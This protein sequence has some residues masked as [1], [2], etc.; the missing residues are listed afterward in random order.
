MKEFI[1]K[2]LVKVL[3][4]F[5]KINYIRRLILFVFRLYSQEITRSWE[6]TLVSFKDIEDNYGHAIRGLEKAL[7]RHETTL[8]HLQEQLQQLVADDKRLKKQVQ[9]V[10]SEACLENT[11]T[12][13]ESRLTS[14]AALKV[15]LI[16]NTYNRLHT[17]PNTLNS[18]N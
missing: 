9:I 5:V 7:H 12:L 15:S 17:L 13:G 6:E 3:T 14:H 8:S 11:S 2:Q 18:L 1:K 4:K 16:I 10:Y